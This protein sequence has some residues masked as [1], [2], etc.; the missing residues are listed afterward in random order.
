[1]MDKIHA[2][3]IIWEALNNPHFELTWL[4]FAASNDEVIWVTTLEVDINRYVI[5]LRATLQGDGRFV[6]TGA[7]VQDWLMATC[8]LDG[9]DLPMALRPTE[10]MVQDAIAQ[11]AKRGAV[12]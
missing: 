7:K 12:L 9:E 4:A 8:V 1:M 6:M 3:Q 10:A 11:I 5:E 2:K